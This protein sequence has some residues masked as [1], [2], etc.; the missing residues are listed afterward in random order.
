[1]ILSKITHT[2][3]VETEMTIRALFKKKEYEEKHCTEDVS[4]EEI[5]LYSDKENDNLHFVQDQVTYNIND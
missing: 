3:R 4:Y 5:D 1:M 2:N